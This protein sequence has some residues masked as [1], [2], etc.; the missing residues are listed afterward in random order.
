M[1][2]LS[3]YLRPPTSA[4]TAPDPSSTTTAPWLT[5]LVSPS[6]AITSC[7]A[8]CAS[9]WS[10]RLTVVSTTMSDVSDPAKPGSTSATQSATYPPDVATFGAATDAGL[11]IA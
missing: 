2:W 10:S 8:L 11:S 3:A 1:Y 6:L 9:S 7:K 5:P 4:F